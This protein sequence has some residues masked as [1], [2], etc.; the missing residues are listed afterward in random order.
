MDINGRQFKRD[1]EKVL[2]Q[3]IELIDTFPTMVEVR[4]VI[5]LKRYIDSIDYQIDNTT[6]KLYIK[7]NTI[8]E[9]DFNIEEYPELW[10]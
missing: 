9:E 6:T 4:Q 1:L 3:K 5:T 7:L 10:I 2:K 8:L